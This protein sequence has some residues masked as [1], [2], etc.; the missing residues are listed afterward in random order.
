M[1][2]DLTGINNVN[3]FYTDHYL[4]AILE[5]DL[6][7]CFKQW[8]AAERDQGVRAPDKC[9][10][11]LRAD[12]FR[13][14]SELERVK[15]PAAIH[16]A[17]RPF[18]AKLLDVLGY[19]PQPTEQPLDGDDAT[20]PVLAGVAK[21]SGAPDL[22]IVETVVP[23]AEPRDPLDVALD[24]CQYA[25]P[26]LAAVPEHDNLEE[27]VSKRIFGRAEPPRWL[28]LLN[29]RCI[30][31][32]DRSKW[33]E[34]RLLR[35]DLR[36]ILDR[37]ENTTLR[38]AAALLHR[39][40][41]CPGDG[42]PLLDALDESSHKHAYA[43]SEDL[44][45]AAREAIELLGNEAVWYIRNVRREGLFGTGKNAALDAEQLTHECLRYLYRLLFLFYIEAREE[46]G[47][48]PL[49]SPEY[50]LGYSLDSLRELE[51]VN[52][53]TDDARNGDYLNE[54]LQLLFGLV[55][56]GFEPSRQD[57]ALADEGL[58]L[59]GTAHHTFDM[60]PLKSHLFDPERTPILT[61]VHFRNHVL[62][63]VIQLL[64]LS[65][66]KGKSGRGARRARRGRISYAQ[67]GINQLGAVYEGLLSYSGFFVAE[68]DGLYEVKKADEAYNELKDAY[69]VPAAELENYSND[70]KFIPQK[71]PD[72]GREDPK[73]KHYFR[74]TFI[75]RLAG[76][77]RQKSASYYTP[78]VLTQCVVK[79]ALKELLPDRTAD[80][81]L[82][83]TVCE[84][85][86][87]S[88][89]FLNEAINQLA[90]A[91]LSARQKETGQRLG[92]D[93]LAEE[94]QK[95]KACIAANNV[96]GVDLNPVATELAEV[97]LWLNT[98]HPGCPVPW[99]NMQLVAGNSLVG[100]RRQ[101][102]SS[103]LL[104][105]KRGDASWLDQVPVRYPLMPGPDDPGS[106]PEHTVYH[107]LLPD[108]G[109][110]SYNNKVVKQMTAYVDPATGEE[111]SRFDDIKN[112]R[113]EFCRPFE[114]HQLDILERLSTQI[115]K[116][117]QTHVRDRQLL[118]TRTRDQWRL[119]QS[120]ADDHPKAETENA[121]PL[122]STQ[123]KDR[124]FNKA[125]LA[126]EVRNSSA[127][128]RLKLV[129]DYWC[130]LWFWPIEKADL[131]PTREVYLLELQAILEGDVYE[132]RYFEGDQALLDLD[133]VGK[134]P[135][136][137]YGQDEFG[138]VNVDALCR[139][140]ARL[141]LVQELADRY[142][143]HHWELEFADLFTERGGFDLVVGN[144]PWIKVEW[145]EGGV[146]GDADPRLVFDKLT[147]SQLTKLRA[148]A[149]TRHPELRG[150]Y[151]AEFEQTDGTQNFLNAGVNCPV[152]G[153]NAANLY[154][155]F[156]LLPELIGHVN[157][158]CGWLHPDTVYGQ[159]GEEGLRGFIY[160]R[161]AYC[162]QF[163]N[164][165]KDVLFRDVGNAKTFCISIQGRLAAQEPSFD[166][167]CN[168]F[169]PGTVDQCYAHRGGG[170]PTGIKDDE[171]DWNLSG[172]RNRVVRVRRGELDV[173]RS[174]FDVPGIPWSCARL[175]TVHSVEIVR[176]LR[177]LAGVGRRMEDLRQLYAGTTFWGETS[178]Q[179][180][181]LIVNA[182][183]FPEQVGEWVLVSAQLQ[184]GNLYH[185]T[186]RRICQTHRSYDRLDACLLPTRFIP[187]SKYRIAGES[188]T[189]IPRL[190]R[191]TAK[192]RRFTDFYRLAA[193]KR[194]DISWERTLHAAICP[195]HVRHIITVFSVCFPDT[196]LLVQAAALFCGLPFDFLV[197][198]FGKSDFIDDVARLLPFPDLKQSVG[199]P[200][201]IRA[202]G[203]NAVTAH[204]ADL[205][206]EC[207][208]DAFRRD[209]WAKSDPRL[210]NAK[211]A[212]LAPEWTRACALRTDFER[213]QALVEID[214]LA[215]MALGLT[216]D[217]LCAIYRIQFPVLRQ[218]END[219]WYDQNGRIVFTC[220][221]G[222]PG[223]GLSR[224]QFEKDNMQK[225]EAQGLIIRGIAPAD[226]TTIKAMPRGAITRTLEDDTIQDYRHAY[227]RFTKDGLTYD[228]PCPDHPTPIEGPVERD[229]TYAA[230]FTKCDREEDYREAWAEFDRRQR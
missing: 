35:F 214:V 228:C 183:D 153:G 157:A 96:Y 101:A 151:L 16:E 195:K 165:R 69:F 134:Q 186:P 87:G 182:P 65:S 28:I 209:R 70:E 144:P 107:F 155:S 114:P 125:I 171:G 223:V 173:F 113:K 112:W 99:F 201:R 184:A 210:D 212:D 27:L 89:A 53:T 30:V 11:G 3:E 196:D 50:R 190:P 60:S 145:S 141:G 38:A 80:E 111:C 118:R 180:S 92:H 178:A 222:L 100:A 103:H 170:L 24:P 73:L 127:Y 126:T 33:N 218:N 149:F 206:A 132:V 32:L 203:L 95:V 193:K 192:G 76:R 159:H 131:L 37:R 158:A 13:L 179:D 20:L 130:A 45:Y 88:G 41:I 152:L 2:I 168:L 36:E 59:T 58:A 198:A 26:A 117:W 124:F 216:C 31:L 15:D 176:V 46:L 204:Y 217:E 84:P 146:L 22:W 98:I 14:L 166:L 106:R 227:G 138:F 77:N 191:T 172:H 219:T 8:T 220:S 66:G 97:S 226:F 164:Q 208:D 25:D 72:T 169:H 49:K 79:Y 63:R 194:I 120:P 67:L 136:L 225:L 143:F 119:W 93:E 121:K 142:R 18:L 102:F 207:W 187:R 181:G 94:R 40:S 51:M 139:D 56:K 200:L 156:L 224:P 29:L 150:L 54:S 205:W 52:L 148:A 44:K 199:V 160:K 86:M 147:A 122:L 34:K 189:D 229:I 61:G 90:D 137:P 167:I 174:L 1:A 154:R 83:L 116:L 42:V 17:Q 230:P 78:E 39:N 109:M 23:L 19:Q 185:Q 188:G 64:S 135:D 55:F 7:D 85:A 91:Y 105:P 197:K 211:F 177:T 62:Q 82:H 140:Y 68:P 74:G 163:Q 215:A 9:L 133:G 48:A 5:N 21:D 71:D 6:K 104:T 57:Q 110:A 221:K 81:I 108:A 175:P 202:L 123:E 213:R 128:R 162:F 10:G 75:Y 12:Y 4:A 47:Y 43:V 129:M 161:L 115:D